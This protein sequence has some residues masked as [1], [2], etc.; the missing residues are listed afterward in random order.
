[1]SRDAKRALALFALGAIVM[2]AFDF[3]LARIAGVALLLG[4]IVAGAFAI[5]TPEFTEDD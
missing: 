5:A 1:M 3:T 2:L 4:A